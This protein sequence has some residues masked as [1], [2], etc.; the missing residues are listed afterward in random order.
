MRS[1]LVTKNIRIIHEISSR[2]RVYCAALHDPDLDPV[3]LEAVIRSISGVTHVRINTRAACVIVSYDGNTGTKKKILSFIENIPEEV[4]QP[5]F[6]C[7]QSTDL[8]TV[9]SR[10]AAALLT[11]YIPGIFKAPVSWILSLPVLLEG[12]DKLITEGIKVEALDASAV[13]FSL[14][15]K[16]FVTA[17]S[18]VAM[19]TLGS[20]MEQLSDQKTTALLTR[21]LRP[22]IKH[23]W[24]EKD[25]VE[26]KIKPE[27]LIIGD[28]IICGTGEL[29]PADGR[30]L[31]GDAL[32]NLSSITGESIPVHIKKG[33]EILSGAVLEEGRVKIEALQVG[34][35]TSMARISRFLENSLRYKSK[36]QTESDKLADKL[37]PITFG[38]GIGLYLLTR[39]INRAAAVLTVDYSC[40]I[41]LATPVA[42]KVAMYTAAKEGVLLKGSGAID[43]LARVDTIVFDKT[44]TLTKG[45]LEVVDIVSFGKMTSDEILSLAA[46]AEEHYTHP[47]ANAV[48]RAASMRKLDLPLI[49]QVDF[50][51]AHGVSAYVGN[52]RVLVGSRHFIHDDEKI[53]CAK[54]DE[55]AASMRSKGE[56]VLFVA[57]GKMLEGVISLRDA[58][59][60]E[61]NSLL[62]KLKNNGI[63]KIIVL[64]GD[65]RETA[66]AV[67]QKI[68]AIDEIYWELNPEDKADI[69]KKLQ[70]QGCFLAFVGDGVNDAPALVTADVGICLPSGAELAKESSQVLLLKDDLNLL[71]TA[72]KIACDTQQTIKRCFNS[73]VG[74]NTSILLLATSGLLQPFTSALLHNTG[75]LGILTYAVLSR[76]RKP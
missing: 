64:T 24:V 35:E 37:V 50:I 41:K 44:G 27:Q 19:L 31:E 5:E 42:V 38:L 15:R 47:V 17:N 62:L 53:D 71:Y 10:A 58:L 2:I 57:R 65:H 68:D 11:P 21:L 9:V 14:L 72:R 28:I 39:D 52:E 45:I 61:A 34:A 6:V 51:V 56:T 48:V 4:Y 70:D 40:A 20:Y 12:I 33:D 29:V 69:I 18:V 8:A 49:G 60:D 23:V 54:S 76:S 32:A 7:E 63:K 36:S 30:V 13:G 26:T 75:T 55:I 73:T 66:K 16:D 3:Y 59:R 22:Q 46:C 67:A 43:S 25:G 74:I 1:D